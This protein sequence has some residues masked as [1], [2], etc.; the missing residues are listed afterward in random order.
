MMLF[1]FSS[2][3]LLKMMIHPQNGAHLPNEL[4]YVNQKSFGY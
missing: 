4:V 2:I 3:L 1:S